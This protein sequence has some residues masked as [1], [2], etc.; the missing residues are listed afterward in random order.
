MSRCDRHARTFSYGIAVS[1]DHRR[2]GL[3]KEAIILV[4]R[5]YFEERGYQKVNTSVWSFNEPSQKLHEQLGF[6]LEGR[7][8]RTHFRAGHFYD[9]LL[10]GMTAEEFAEGHPLT[11]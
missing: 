11:G 10:Y 4:L 6:V 1:G 5:F 7:L 9:E 8:R 2:L 3:A